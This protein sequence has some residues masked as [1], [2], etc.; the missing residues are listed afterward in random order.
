MSWCFKLNCCLQDFDFS[1]V[2]KKT[3]KTLDGFLLFN[4]VPLGN[5]TKFTNSFSNSL[6]IWKVNRQEYQCENPLTKVITIFWFKWVFRRMRLKNI[7][8]L[9][10]RCVK[11]QWCYGYGHW[12]HS[13]S[14]IIAA[15]YSK[16]KL[17]KSWTPLRNQPSQ[18]KW[19]RFHS[20]KRAIAH[21]IVHGHWKQIL[22][23]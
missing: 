15:V 10:S 14:N 8:L 21:A 9:M 4:I 3:R 20:L 22:S 16:G 23:K 18:N 6:F 19:I 11:A 13:F 5:V 2:W 12:K 17:T 1:T 7:S